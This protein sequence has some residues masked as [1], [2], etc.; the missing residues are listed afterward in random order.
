VLSIG[1]HGVWLGDGAEFAV[2]DSKGWR[3]LFINQIMQ[4]TFEKLRGKLS[5]VVRR[6]QQIHSNDP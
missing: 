6:W 2:D 1:E 4:R 3:R 5:S